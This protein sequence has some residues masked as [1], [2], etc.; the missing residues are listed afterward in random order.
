MS[1][2]GLLVQD[3]Q[4]EMC[5]GNCRVR[6][7]TQETAD[8]RSA[9]RNVVKGVSQRLEM[10]IDGTGD[11]DV[12]KC[13]SPQDGP[14]YC[15][16]VV[17]ST[18]LIYIARVYTSVVHRKQPVAGGSSGMLS[19]LTRTSADRL[20]TFLQL[21]YHTIDVECRVAACLGPELLEHVAV[22]C[23]QR[24]LASLGDHTTLDPHLRSF[25]HCEIGAL[26]DVERGNLG[27]AGAQALVEEWLD[28]VSLMSYTDTHE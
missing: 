14:F 5:F 8:L 26:R 15:C 19:R 20:S 27:I 22:F 25:S 17:V 3:S 2:L 28:V 13:Q 16:L 23:F 12:G 21:G 9:L 11:E 4:V 6:R 10:L 7:G 1:G 18:G 24:F